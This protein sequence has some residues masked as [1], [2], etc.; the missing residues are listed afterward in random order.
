MTVKNDSKAGGLPDNVK[1]K[2]ELLGKAG[3]C[4][5]TKWTAKGRD[6]KDVRM[7]TGM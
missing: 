6:K 1:V 4:E 2:Q 3:E 7:T 5:G